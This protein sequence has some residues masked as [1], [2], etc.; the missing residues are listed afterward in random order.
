MKQLLAILSVVLISASL[1]AQSG[2]DYVKTNDETFFFKKIKV[3]KD[4]SISGIK[5]NGERSTFDKDEVTAYVV[6]GDYYQKMPVFENNV[7]TGEK[8]FMKLIETKKGMV[9]LEYKTQNK[10]T[11]YFV[12]KDQQLVVEMDEKNKQSLTAYFDLY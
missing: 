2:G 8:D 4:E 3:N 12:F 11:K 10:I 7:F 6:K 9:L 5:S 1:T